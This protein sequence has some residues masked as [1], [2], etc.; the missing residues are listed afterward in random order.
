MIKTIFFHQFILSISKLSLMQRDL[1]I[2]K[3]LLKDVF[4]FLFRCFMIL[5]S[6]FRHY[7]ASEKCN[8]M[9]TSLNACS[10]KIQVTSSHHQ[11]QESWACF[12]G[13][14]NNRRKK[15]RLPC[16]VPRFSE[17][18]SRSV[19]AH[20]QTDFDGEADL[21]RRGRTV[22]YSARPM[23]TSSGRKNR[24]IPPNRARYMVMLNN[25]L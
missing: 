14:P 3:T 16:P 18:K 1:H 11:S 5:K 15:T 17:G 8:S 21:L 12:A 2:L 10:D 7:A 22:K 13:I 4:I 23:P 19:K 25:R 9:W 24:A 20:H 6:K